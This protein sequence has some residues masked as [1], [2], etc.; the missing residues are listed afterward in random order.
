MVRVAL[1]SF[2]KTVV[3]LA[4]KIITQFLF[5]SVTD[6][7]EYKNQKTRGLQLYLNLTKKKEK[8]S[9]KGNEINLLGTTHSVTKT[10]IKI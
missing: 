5:V 7:K 3:K 9:K 8:T 2:P 1:K 6:L 10:P 4:F